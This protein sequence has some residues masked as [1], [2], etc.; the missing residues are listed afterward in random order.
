ME[1]SEKVINETLPTLTIIIGIIIGF[2]IIIIGMYMVMYD[3]EGE[4]LR[5]IGTITQSKY[6]RVSMSYNKESKQENIYKYS[7]FVTYMI[8]NVAYAKKLFVSDKTQYVKDNT[9]DLIIHKN[10]YT[11]VQL[12]YT[13]KSSFGIILMIIALIIIGLVYLT[14]YLTYNYKTYAAS[15]REINLFLEKERNMN[16]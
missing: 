7:I 10:D 8:D 9:I 3:E 12:A 11:N 15:Q 2:V 1:K 6:E 16:Y 13:R 4:Y 14:Y 5:V